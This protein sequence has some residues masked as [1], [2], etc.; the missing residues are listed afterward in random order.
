MKRKFVVEYEETH[1]P[2]APPQRRRGSKKAWWIAV[3]GVTAAVI[4][5]VAALIKTGVIHL[6]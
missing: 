1:D 4:S 5:L 6:P 3:M 2:Q